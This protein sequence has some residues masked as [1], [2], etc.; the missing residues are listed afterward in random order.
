MKLYSTVFFLLF[1]CFVVIWTVALR[2]LHMGKNFTQ[3]ICDATGVL[4]SFRRR[5]ASLAYHDQNVCA[6]FRG[7]PLKTFIALYCTKYNKI[8]LHEMTYWKTKRFLEHIRAN[9]C[10]L[11]S[12]VRTECENNV[13]DYIIMKLHGKMF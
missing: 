12:F 10:C 3:N 6:L 9:L 2:F 1:L 7:C 4:L 11:I 8:F 13:K 5:L